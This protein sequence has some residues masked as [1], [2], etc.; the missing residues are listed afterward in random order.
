MGADGSAQCPLQ[1]AVSHRARDTDGSSG[2][3]CVYLF[4]IYIL[5]KSFLNGPMDSL[6]ADTYDEA[7]FNLSL[8]LICFCT[9]SGAIITL[10]VTLSPWVAIST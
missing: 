3:N 5:V 10:D 8:V 2:N 4:Q 7:G 6:E 1:I 9:K